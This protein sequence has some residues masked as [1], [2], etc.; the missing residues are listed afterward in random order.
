MTIYLGIDWDTKQLKTFWQTENQKP[1]RLIFSEPTFE[2]VK[3]VIQTI[4]KKKEK[5]IIAV[6]ESGAPQ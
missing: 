2:Q 6:I 1:Q 3:K 4:Q 5:E